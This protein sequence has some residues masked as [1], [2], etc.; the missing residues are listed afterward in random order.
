M[1][2]LDLFIRLYGY[3]ALFAGMV[4]EQFVPPIAGE[5]VLLAVGGPS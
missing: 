4:I 1:E 3:P 5:P 2:S